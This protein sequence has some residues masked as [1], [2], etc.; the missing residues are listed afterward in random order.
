MHMYQGHL[1]HVVYRLVSILILFGIVSA[2][3]SPTELE[4]SLLA[5]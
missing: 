1:F 3:G 4:I 2:D 5:N